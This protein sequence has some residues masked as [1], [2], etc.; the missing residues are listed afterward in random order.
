MSQ[1]TISVPM[2]DLAAL[3]K[4][5]MSR[6]EG[7][8]LEVIVS[9]LPPALMGIVFDRRKIRRARSIAVDLKSNLDSV[10]EQDE[11]LSDIDTDSQY[12]EQVI[13]DRDMFIIA[14]TRQKKTLAG[15]IEANNLNEADLK[16]GVIDPVISGLRKIA[17]DECHGFEI[18]EI[19]TGV[20]ISTFSGVS[21]FVL[22][23]ELCQRVAE[24]N[25]DFLLIFSGLLA[26]L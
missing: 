21:D 8:P 24:V 17:D 4:D 5:P 23:R 18:F 15:V 22:F 20:E 26:E 3:K 10:D 2:L 7:V 19:S 9:S 6:K 25:K 13:K 14:A 12:R 16:Q 11:I 1:E